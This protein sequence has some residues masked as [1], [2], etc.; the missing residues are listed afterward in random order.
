LSRFFRRGKKK[1][2]EAKQPG[3]ARETAPKTMTEL[4]KLCW[5]DKETYQALFGIMF[6]DP[7]KTGT[8]MKE[9]AENAKKAEKADDPVKAKFWYEIAGGMAIYE[10]DVRKVVEY[11]SQCQKISPEME[12]LILKVPEKAVAKAQEYYKKFL[13]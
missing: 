13:G 8:T 3:K 11:F 2:R 4:E 9:A 7:R 6:L 5:N 1:D 10:G 12:Y